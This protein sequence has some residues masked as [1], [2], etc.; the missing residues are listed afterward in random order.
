MYCINLLKARMQVRSK[1]QKT[2]SSSP[3]NFDY[4]IKALWFVYMVDH[5]QTAMVHDGEYNYPYSQPRLFLPCSVYAR[6]K[7]SLKL[8][9]I[10]ADEKV[11]L[12][13]LNRTSL[14]SAK[15]RRKEHCSQEVPCRPALIIYITHHL[16]PCL[17]LSYSAIPT[18]SHDLQAYPSTW[19]SPISSLDNEPVFES[20]FADIILM[21]N[22]G[23]ATSSNANI[24][25]R[26]DAIPD[27]M[28]V[29]HELGKSSRQLGVQLPAW[30]LKTDHVLSYN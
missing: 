23:S 5:G 9:G 28:L 30:L 16:N 22:A 15:Y 10:C 17:Y 6:I 14:Y 2:S 11:Q 13:L 20:T 25:L 18:H 8:Q 26:E 12:L 1:A 27:E 19:I 4:A 3:L 7:Y 29:R 21:I 24:S